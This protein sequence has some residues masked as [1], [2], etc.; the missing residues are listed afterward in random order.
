[1]RG[2]FPESFLA[3]DD[4]ASF[5]WREQFVRTFLDRDIPSLGID[6]TRSALERL[7]TMVAASN[8]TILNRAKL[9][10][11]VGVSP[12]TISRYLDILESTF[13]IRLLRPFFANTKKRL[14]RSPKVYLRDSG[15]LHALLGIRTWNELYGHPAIGA[16][17][18]AYAVEQIL[19]SAPEWQASFYRTSAGAEVDLVLQRAGRTVAVEFRAAQAPRVTRGF[20]QAAQDIGAT[21]RFVVAPLARREIIPFG[22]GTYLCR[23]E[24]LMARLG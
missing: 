20:Y 1:M 19:G 8:G 13:M 9:A 18:E 2:G 3:R 23:P 17:W 24:D 22:S 10:D 7:W 21:E 15:L 6:L 14:V 4:A 12:Q 5:R 16:S 11:P